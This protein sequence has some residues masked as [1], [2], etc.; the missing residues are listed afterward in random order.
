MRAMKT[1]PNPISSIPDC[2]IRDEPVLPVLTK[3]AK[4][5]ITTRLARR[6]EPERIAAGLRAL[7]QI[8]IAPAQ[9]VPYW[10]GALTPPTT[11]TERRQDKESVQIPADEAQEPLFT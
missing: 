1:T 11:Q 10:Q 4:D 2:S 9:V 5:F 3:R 8:E 7:F 6:E